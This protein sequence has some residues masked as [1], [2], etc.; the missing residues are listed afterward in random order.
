[1]NEKGMP[2]VL[3]TKLFIPSQV[4]FFRNLFLKI[5]SP[6]DFIVFNTCFEF[7]KHVLSVLPQQHDFHS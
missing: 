2:I 3:K 7:F 1:M 4:R 5:H 6:L